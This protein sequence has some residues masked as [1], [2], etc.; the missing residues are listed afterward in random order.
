MII[1][2]SSAQS[3]W[4]ETLPTVRGRYQID[5]PLQEQTWFRVGGPADVLFKPADTADL[6]HFLQ[7]CPRDVPVTILGAASNVLV[8]DGGIAGVTIRLMGR[9]FAD[10]Q[11]DPTLSRIEVGAGALDR[12]VALTSAQHQIVGLEF[13]VGIPGTIGGAVKMNAGAYE[14]EIKDV[15]V[16]CDVVTPEGNCH[17]LSPADLGFSYR[18]CALPEGW[19]VVRACLQGRTFSTESAN[20]PDHE[21]PMQKIER[22]L[23]QREASQPTKGRTG[24]STFKNP[25]G[26]KAW[27]LIDAAGCR[28]LTKGGAEVSTKHCNFLLNVNHA[29]AYDLETL[30]ETVRA[31]VLETTGIP[32]EWEILRL[33][34]FAILNADEE[35]LTMRKSACFFSSDKN[36]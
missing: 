2:P 33:G 21:S 26:E 30:G 18:H 28:G 16:W 1:P 20:A 7:H 34:R 27:A 36:R 19:I 24:G 12:V 31:R 13:L 8:R 25:E 35:P 4:I 15:L 22:F 6:Q 29:S 23:A 11:V 10:I 3:S 32:L 9:G 14:G 5:A 17:R